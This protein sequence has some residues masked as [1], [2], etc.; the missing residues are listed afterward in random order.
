MSS[1]SDIRAYNRDAW[2]H[3]VECGN[4]WTKPV[5]TE[6]I[7][8]ARTGKWSVLLT[9]SKPVPIGGSRPSQVSTCCVASGGGQQGPIFAA[10]GARVTV[11]DNS[12]RQL[13]QDRLVADREQLALELVEGDM[14]DLSEFANESFDLVFHPVSNLFVP[15]VRPVW[16]E[17]FRVLRPGGRL[18]AGFLNPVVYLFDIDEVDRSELIVRH[19]IPYEDIRDLSPERRGRLEAEQQPLEFS[20]TLTEQIGGQLD[21]G[22]VL[23]DMYEDHHTDFAPAR[24]FPTYLATHALKPIRAG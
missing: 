10:G 15:E 17:A 12:P 16:R 19:A 14:A 22:F 4:R 23:I 2:N 21:A 9:E 1:A 3:E 24:Y 7:A 8:L 11:F 13:A 6:T 20:H 18:L 5:T